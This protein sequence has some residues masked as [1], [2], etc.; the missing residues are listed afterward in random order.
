[1]NNSNVYGFDEETKTEC[2]SEP[3]SKKR[4]K[5]KKRAKYNIIS[6]CGFQGKLFK[7]KSRYAH[8]KSDKMDAI[9]HEHHEFKKNTD[10]YIQCLKSLHY[11]SSLR[12][13]EKIN[14]CTMVCIL[15]PPINYALKNKTEIIPAGGRYNTEQLLYKYH[16]GVYALGIIS[17]IFVKPFRYVTSKNESFKET[18]PI[19]YDMKQFVQN[20]QDNSITR[21]SDFL[22]IIFGV[23]FAIPSFDGYNQNKHYSPIYRTA[24][25]K[26]YTPKTDT[27]SVNINVSAPSNKWNSPVGIMLL[28]KSC[29]YINNHDC[30]STHFTIKYLLR[31]L[32][33]K[34]IKYKYD[35]NPF[36]KKII[37]RKYDDIKIMHKIWCD[38]W[39]D[40]QKYLFKKRKW[41]KYLDMLNNDRTLYDNIANNTDFIEGGHE[42]GSYLFNNK[43]TNISVEFACNFLLAKKNKSVQWLGD[44]QHS[45]VSLYRF[46]MDIIINTPYA[47]LFKQ[48]QKNR[49]NFNK[50]RRECIWKKLNAHVKKPKQKRKRKDKTNRNGNAINSGKSNRRYNTRSRA[51]NSNNK[52]H[53]ILT[54]QSDAYAE[55]DVQQQ[56]KLVVHSY[57][58]FID[59]MA[60]I[61]DLFGGNPRVMKSVRSNFIIFNFGIHCGNAVTNGR[62]INASRAEQMLNRVLP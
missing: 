32:R 48:M 20:K 42:L 51:T 3:P 19:I 45:N 59:Q 17:E 4:K 57:D 10:Q 50:K 60:N 28:I 33:W 55:D 14:N 18:Y 46:V 35:I 6:Q 61:Q 53:N 36:V 25:H 8:Q 7:R 22:S 1:M 30:V 54:A 29:R 9:I 44:I 40:W 38:V 43:N 58:E 47:E 16:V 49:A 13:L 5:N 26:L 11:N 24:L 31:V 21:M 23:H 39:N 12:N 62:E 37:C 2:D 56:S 34:I 27:Y 52:P 41:D 15:S